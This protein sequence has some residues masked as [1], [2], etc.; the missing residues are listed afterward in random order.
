MAFQYTGGSVTKALKA[1]AEVVK[2]S[3]EK[4]G[5]WKGLDDEELK[6][7]QKDIKDFLALIE[8]KKGTLDNS[9]EEAATLAP[10]PPHITP[11]EQSHKDQ[12]CT[13]P[14]VTD[15]GEDGELAVMVQATEESKEKIFVSKAVDKL[16]G[17]IRK[18][19]YHALL[20][21]FTTKKLVKSAVTKVV[22]QHPESNRFTK[23]GGKV[24][25]SAHKFIHRAR[26]NL[27]VCNF[28]TWSGQSKECRRC[29]HPKESQD[30]IL[31]SC[32]YGLPKLITQRH[33][34]VLWKVKEMIEKGKKKDWKLSIDKSL[35]GHGELRPDITLV[36]EDKKEYIFADVTCPYET[37]KMM[38]EG[39]NRKIEKYDSAYK[40]LRKQGKKV[41]VLPIVV[42][43]L[44]TW[45]KPTTASLVALGIEE[46]AVKRE[47]PEICST[48]LEYSKNVYWNHIYGDHFSR[49]PMKFGKEKPRGN[50]WKNEIE[51]DGSKIQ[52]E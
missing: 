30:H 23:V 50:S 5:F 22:L 32:R 43:S 14:Q 49:P 51:K 15:S 18:E 6:I 24:S 41:T 36:S 37:M 35:Q 46:A 1:L 12:R 16:Q 52:S 42:G 20:H 25:I 26:L 34:A 2:N 7:Q 19:L 33:D 28:N 29:G 44:G 13:F 45:W 4:L 10:P 21:R 38:Q 9:C 3:T 39:W 48:V 40:H 8:A 47:I 17:F 31:Q 11:L 27:L